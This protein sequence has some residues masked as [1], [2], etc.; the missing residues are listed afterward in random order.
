[1][2]VNCKHWA[3]GHC[4]IGHD[5]TK[6]DICKHREVRATIGIPANVARR[7]PQVPKAS[8]KTKVAAVMRKAAS[9][10]NA[11]A[12]V[13]IEGKLADADYEARIAACRACEHLSPLP[14][15]QV[16]FCGG[17]GCGKSP[18]AELTVKGRMPAARCPKR[19]WP[20]TQTPAR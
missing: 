13:L 10:L 9:W 1:M 2:L 18:R 11:E 7:L 8:L 6:C 14:E 19:K 3:S 15:P 5:A 16:G 4:I 20:E 17:C 12:S